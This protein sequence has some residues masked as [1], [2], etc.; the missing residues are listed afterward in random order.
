MTNLLWQ[1]EENRQKDCYAHFNILYLQNK[2]ICFIWK[3]QA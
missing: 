3:H 2:S 1:I